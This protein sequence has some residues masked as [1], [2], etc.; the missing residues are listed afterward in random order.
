MNPIFSSEMSI[1]NV[2]EG[3]TN[4]QSQHVI[5]AARLAQVEKYDKQKKKH[6]IS[7]VV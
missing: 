7:L 3:Y 1:F 6:L 4:V 5:L 2:S